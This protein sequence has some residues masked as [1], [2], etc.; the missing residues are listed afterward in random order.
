[1]ILHDELDRLVPIEHSRAEAEAN[2]WISLQPT[3][4]LGHTRIL[5]SDTAVAAVNCYLLQPIREAS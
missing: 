1:V 3:R 5:K 4:N 2:S